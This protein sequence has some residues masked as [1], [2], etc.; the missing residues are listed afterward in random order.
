MF[1]FEKKENL[2]QWNCIRIAV[3][4]SGNCFISIPELESPKISDW[5]EKPQVF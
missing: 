2:S 5:S 1:G 4:I 3:D